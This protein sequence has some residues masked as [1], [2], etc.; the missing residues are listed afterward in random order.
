[1]GHD[2]TR[3]SEPKRMHPLL[4]T[5]HKIGLCRYCKLEIESRDLRFGS[6]I[7]CLE[8]HLSLN[9]PEAS[10]STQTKWSRYYEK[11]KE[12]KK[13]SS[14]AYYHKN[15]ERIKA[16]KIKEYHDDIESSRQYLREYRRANP[17]KFQQ[18]RKKE[19]L[20]KEAV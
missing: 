4:K 17:E 14:R 1:M 10:I 8:P 20:K 5:E 7:E 19:K 6:C 13:A 15:K 16:Q 3:P 2:S 12:R 9:T 11:N 18:Y